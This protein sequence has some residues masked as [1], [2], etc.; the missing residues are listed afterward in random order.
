LRPSRPLKSKINYDKLRRRSSE[1]RGGVILGL[2]LLF[3]SIKYGI[4]AFNPETEEMELALELKLGKSG[5]IKAKATRGHENMKAAVLAQHMIINN[6]KGAV[7]ATSDPQAWLEAL[8]D[9]F[10]GTYVCAE[11]L[12]KGG[13]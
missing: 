8:P 4:F 2:V 12:S 10:R 5:K 9:N 3:M 6:G 11:L 7:T 1:G 13:K